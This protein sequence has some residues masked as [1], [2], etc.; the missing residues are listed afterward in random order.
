MLPR[1]T[2][3]GR[4]PKCKTKSELEVISGTPGREKFRCNQCYHNFG[5]DEL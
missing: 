5:M 1:K 2:I 4:C 3:Y